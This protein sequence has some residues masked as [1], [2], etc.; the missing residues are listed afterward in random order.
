VV[1]VEVSPWLLVVSIVFALFLALAKRRQELTTLTDASAHRPSL[2]E[3]SERLLDQLLAMTGASVIM[4]YALY[5]IDSPNAVT[6]RWL[7]G[8]IPFVIFGIFRYFYL[9]YEKGLGGSPEDVLL[10]DRPLQIDLALWA[11]AIIAILYLPR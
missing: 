9:I 7:K 1:R 4:A 3:Y 2:E 6:S 10:T 5:T 8:T 11:G